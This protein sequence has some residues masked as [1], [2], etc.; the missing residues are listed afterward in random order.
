MWRRRARAS[1]AALRHRCT[2]WQPWRCQWQEKLHGATSAAWRDV[3][4][5]YK[6]G[7]TAR[8]LQAVYAGVPALK[9]AEPQFRALGLALLECSVLRHR[10]TQIPALRKVGLWK[11]LQS[12][13]AG[14]VRYQSRHDLDLLG[15][16]GLSRLRA[17]AA[18]RLAAVRV[19]DG[20]GR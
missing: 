12:K 17:R 2:W 15:T 7:E 16:A 13:H 9:H 3:A 11:Q 20:E 5:F 8:L 14:E 6:N 1:R 10:E 4:I 19:G 18:K